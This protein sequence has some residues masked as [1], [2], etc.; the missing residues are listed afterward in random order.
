MDQEI[1]R[2]EAGICPKCN[3]PSDDL[4]PL[5]LGTEKICFL[6]AMKTV[7]P[8]VNI[9]EISIADLLTILAST[10]ESEQEERKEYDC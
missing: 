8:G 9:I 6:C 2:K 4:R 1:T 10:K 7:A 3:Q 5:T